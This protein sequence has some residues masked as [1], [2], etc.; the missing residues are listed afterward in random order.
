LLK[1]EEVG[2]VRTVPM[3]FCRQPSESTC[4]QKVHPLSML[5]KRKKNM[6][7]LFGFLEDTGR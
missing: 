2:V 3:C 1:T 6:R 4:S 7:Y 5:G